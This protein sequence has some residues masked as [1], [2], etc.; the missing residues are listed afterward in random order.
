MEPDDLAA[1]TPFTF[2]EVVSASRDPLI[3]AFVIGNSFVVLPMIVDAV[4]RLQPKDELPGSPTADQQEYLVPLAY[5]FPDV[6]KIVSIVFIPF[7][8]W[9]YGNVIDVETYPTIMGVG[10][11]G[12]FGIVP[13]MDA[14]L[15][16]V[17]GYHRFHKQLQQRVQKVLKPQATM[18]T[19]KSC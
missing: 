2:R 14:S 13:V 16:D 5:P 10:L 17:S 19:E 15:T 18:S 6:G 4:K 9:F 1:V 7:A 8:A 12:A 11:L 3:A